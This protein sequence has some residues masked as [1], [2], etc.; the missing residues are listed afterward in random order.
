M[1][2]IK[3]FGMT[4]NYNTKQSEHLHINFTKDAYRTTNHKDEYPQMTRWLE[5]HEKIQQH[6]AFINRRQQN[7]QQQLQF[8]KPVRPLRGDR[9][10][11]WV[12][13]FK[14]VPVPLDTV[15]ERLRV[16]V[17]PTLFIGYPRHT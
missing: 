7:Q 1:S 17:T 8:W 15:T 11:P 3:L 10:N 5:H 9:G 13:F 4:D 6:T 14:P 16:R 2:S 12:F